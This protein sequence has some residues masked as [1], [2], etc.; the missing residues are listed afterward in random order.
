LGYHKECSFVSREVFFS[1]WLQI[2]ANSMTRLLNQVS[3]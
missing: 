3:N 2:L 1:I